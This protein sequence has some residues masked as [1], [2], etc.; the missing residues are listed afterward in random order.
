MIFGRDDCLI[1]MITE[2]GD[3]IY[4]E[5]ASG[6]VQVI[7][8]DGNPDDC[9]RELHRGRIDLSMSK[10]G[11]MTWSNTVGIRMR[12]LGIVRIFYDGN[13]W[14]TATNGLENKILEHGQNCSF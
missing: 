9:I 6:N 8:E 2:D 11:C 4:T 3:R 14:D 1:L 7:P 13:V 10:N 12:P 5:D